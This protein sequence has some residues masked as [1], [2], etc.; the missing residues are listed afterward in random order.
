MKGNL[1]MYSKALRSNQW[2]ISLNVFFHMLNETRDAKDKKIAL[3]KQKQH[4]H[5][6]I[7]CALHVF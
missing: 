2:V 7:I 1:D 6:I 3:K 5:H 4:K